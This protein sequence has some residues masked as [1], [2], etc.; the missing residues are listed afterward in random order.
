M[1][2]LPIIIFFFIAGCNNI[3]LNVQKFNGYEL[4]DSVTYSNVT[5]HEWP[6]PCGRFLPIFYLG[7]KSAKVTLN[8]KPLFM[9]KCIPTGC[10]SEFI[11]DTP[12]TNPRSI[13]V[14]LKITVSD[15]VN[16]GEE[17]KYGRY[18]NQQELEIDSIKVKKSL[19]LEVYNNSNKPFVLCDIKR[20]IIQ[21]KRND[22]TWIDIFTYETLCYLNEF[23]VLIPSKEMIIT[24]LP[25]YYGDTLVV[26]RLMAVGQN[27]SSCSNEFKYYSHK[28]QFKTEST[29]D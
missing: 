24:K 8:K 15:N 13:L 26:C 6:I 22:R 2:S 29:Y 12:Y 7:D 11:V 28:W 5:F 20:L 21:A 16:L 18:Y 23:K 9:Q 25:S 27:D 17:I 1:R 4:I 19:P 10:E 3:G 14:G